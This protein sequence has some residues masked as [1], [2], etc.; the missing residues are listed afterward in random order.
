[1]NIS[2]L[3]QQKL[4][5][6][7]LALETQRKTVMALTVL[8][9]VLAMISLVVSVRFIEHVFIVLPVCIVAVVLV[10]YYQRMHK[11]AY[12]ASYKH[13]VVREIV[14]A[15]DSSYRYYPS[16]HIDSH[17]FAASGLFP[18]TWDTFIGDDLV[19]G[20]IG[21]TDFEFSEI[22]AQ[23]K[24]EARRA[25]GK[26]QV[27]YETVFRG[28]FMHADF[29]KNL[30]TATYV[31]PDGGL[32]FDKLNHR[33]ASAQCR[34]VKLENLT[35]EEHFEVMSFD[36]IE[37]RYVLTPRMMEAMVDIKRSLP[38]NQFYYAFLGH[39]MY[40]G[41]K[42]NQEMFEPAIFR[43]GVNLTDVNLMVKALRLTKLVIEEMDLNTRI[44]TKQ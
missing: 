11:R 4:K 1:M 10:G 35:F 30:T 5:P 18:Q 3:Y 8:P 9:P 20:K 44:W 15:V 29:N 13:L 25:N 22:H 41:V 14:K 21:Q 38:N 37:A 32:F 7:L 2:L 28:L 6:R 12:V 16:R 19:T 17:Y 31:V 42:F 43:S 23:L 33:K 27:Q 24:R 39:R 36:Q 40:C 34:P 26:T